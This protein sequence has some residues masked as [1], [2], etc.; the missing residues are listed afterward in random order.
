MEGTRLTVGT[1]TFWLFG[2][3]DEARL[4][5]MQREL[6]RRSY[7]IGVSFKA[8]VPETTWQSS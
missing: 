3:V 7:Q 1:V 8:P 5:A 4:A 6:E 2:P